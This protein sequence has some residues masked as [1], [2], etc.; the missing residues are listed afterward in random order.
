MKIHIYIVLIGLVLSNCVS[1]QPELR[2][3]MSE[4]E[5]QVLLWHQNRNERLNQPNGWLTLAGLFWLEEGNNR[6]GSDPDNHLV[7][8]GGL[9]PAFMGVLHLKGESVSIIVADSIPILLGDS[10]IIA[11]ELIKDSDGEPDLLTWENLSWYIIQ[12]GDRIGVRLRDSQHPNYVDF[13]P[14]ELFAV[15]SS[16]RVPATLVFFDSSTT[17]DIVNVLG[18]TEPS[19]TPG[20]LHFEIN[21]REYALTPL[22]DPDDTSYF[23][24]FGDQTNGITTYGAGRFL[25]IP[26]ADEN[27]KTVIDFNKSYNM[28]CAFSPW[29]TCP[30][31]PPENQLSVAIN[32]GELA[33]VYKSVLK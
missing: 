7:F 23:I 19:S 6:F 27:G 9:V 26:A 3:E 18:D 10:L 32:A 5:K 28:P 20:I 15:D 1:T 2:K 33:Y 8:P 21:G 14:T 25:V 29:A 22:G 13:K 17:V 16:W 24:I 11:S 12:R 31:P 4:Y 30:L